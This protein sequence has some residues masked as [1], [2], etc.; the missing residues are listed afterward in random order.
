MPDTKEGEMAEK[1]TEKTA[2]NKQGFTPVQRSSILEQHSST[3]K[4]S[5]TARDQAAG[6][7]AAGDQAAGDQATGDQVAGYQITGKATS[8][9]ARARKSAA[10]RPC[11]CPDQALPP[12][13]AKKKTNITRELTDYMP[14]GPSLLPPRC[15]RQSA[16]STTPR[17]CWVR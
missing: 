14:E 1:V 3:S 16:W 5:K 8:E 15:R 9:R 6:D 13:I 10:K 11:N 7:Q 12:D 17:H 2:P 4:P